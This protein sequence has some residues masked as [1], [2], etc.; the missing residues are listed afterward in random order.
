MKDSGKQRKARGNLP[1]E[2]SCKRYTW[3]WKEGYIQETTC[4]FLSSGQWS[5]WL[6]R[7]LEEKHQEDWRQEGLGNRHVAGHLAVGTKY[8]D[9]CITRQYTPE[10]TYY[11]KEQLS[12]LNDSATLSLAILELAQQAYEWSWL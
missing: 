8:E 6:V 12:R 2:Q 10:S 1:N 11:Q 4:T 9:F 7:G 5:S 3:L